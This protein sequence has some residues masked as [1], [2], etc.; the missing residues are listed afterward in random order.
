MRRFAA[1]T[2]AA[3]L[4]LCPSA[5][6][7]DKQL[8]LATTTSVENS[9]LLTH[10]LPDF[11]KQ[12]A[13]FVRV[14]P[15]GTGKALTLGQQGD[16]DAL[17]THSPTDEKRFVAAGNGVYRRLI[18]HNYFVL[19]GPPN[20]PAK[21]QQAA[22]IASAM[23]IIADNQIPFVS[24]GDNSGTHKMELSLWEKTA[25]RI[26]TGADW[27]LSAG[28][29]M[30]QAL[31]LADELNAYIL[32]DHGT[33][34]YFQDKIRLQILSQ[35]DPALY[36]PYSVILVNPKKHPHVNFHLAQQF[37]DW[38]TNE[39]TQAKIAN[40]RVKGTIL[41]TPGAADKH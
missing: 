11:E 31:I 25:R 28:I 8:V 9:G 39:K 7:N 30:G 16:I 21:V 27:Y 19:L 12:C 20:D 24:R 36:N 37:S 1:L 22:S 2:I 3:I 41:F 38:L 34:V 5:P 23:T 4:L 10:L 13:C 18:M 15:V 14:I 26:P 35:N 33:Y 32:S 6:A 17:I 40:Y 29:G